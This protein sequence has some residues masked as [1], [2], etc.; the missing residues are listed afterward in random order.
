MDKI[1]AKLRMVDFELKNI[2]IYRL[3][4]TN[5]RVYD[6][7][8]Q[9]RNRHLLHLVTSGNREYEFDGKRMSFNDGTLIFIPEGT[10]YKTFSGTNCSGI[11]IIFECEGL[12]SKAETGVFFSEEASYTPKLKKLFEDACAQYKNSPLD[13]LI[14]KASVYNIFSFLINAFKQESAEYMII[15]PAVDYITEHYSENLPIKDYADVCNLSESY[16]R[17]KFANY[18]GMSPID[19]RNTLRFAEAK[20]LYQNGFDSEYIAEQ[21][22]FCD[23][24]Y[25]FKLYKRKNGISLKTEARFV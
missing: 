14:L 1:L 13:I 5:T 7:T 17:K 21:L 16:F 2:D 8:K 19:Y 10:K 11:G 20:R 12:F 22:G 15:K 3:E 18:M 23:A 25:M 24:S 6:Y 9:G 4:I